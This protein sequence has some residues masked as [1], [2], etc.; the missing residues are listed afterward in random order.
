MTNFDLCISSDAEGSEVLVLVLEKEDL[1]LLGDLS[2]SRVETNTLH[3]T[4][5]TLDF[6]HGQVCCRL[7]EKVCEAISDFEHLWVCVVDEELGVVF[8]GQSRLIFSR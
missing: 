8:E 1:P 6:S 3:Q 4:I 7:P 5:L 2:V